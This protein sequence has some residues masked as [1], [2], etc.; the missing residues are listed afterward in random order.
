MHYKN[1]FMN[2][3][4]SA[5][6]LSENEANRGQ[7]CCSVV[8]V[9]GTNDHTIQSSLLTTRYTSYAYCKPGTINFKNRYSVSNPKGYQPYHMKYKQVLHK[10]EEMCGGSSIVIG[11]GQFAGVAE[12]LL[13]IIGKK[14]LLRKF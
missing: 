2:F 1:K 9:N 14:F 6:I 8:V 12:A 4:E 3:R 5:D 11:Y 10:Y 7:D 13:I